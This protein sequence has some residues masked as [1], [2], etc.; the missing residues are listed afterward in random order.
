MLF[1]NWEHRDADK[2]VY[3]RL[4]SFEI[5]AYIMAYGNYENDDYDEQSINDDI[6]ERIKL[7]SS[8][9]SELK[10]IDLPLRS[11]GTPK[12]PMTWQIDKQKEEITNL[13]IAGINESPEN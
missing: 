5:A 8:K 4:E 6:K 11:G 9:L 7:V 10:R 3:D 2:L 13:L 12:H 1:S